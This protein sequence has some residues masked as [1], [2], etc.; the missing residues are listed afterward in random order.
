MTTIFGVPVDAAYHLVS[1]FTIVLTPV[2]GGLA[3]VAAIIAITVAVRLLLMPLSFRALRG[4][5]IAARLAPQLQVLRQRHAKQPERLQREMTALYKREGTS[6][7]ASITP[8]LLQWPLLSVMYL[9]FRSAQVGGKPNTLLTHDLFGVALGSHWLSGPG[10]ASVAGLVFLGVLALLAGLVWLSVRLSQLM[11][12]QATAVPAKAPAS[13]KAPVPARARAGGAQRAATKTAP[14]AAAQAPPVPGGALVK[15]LP[16]LTVVIAAFAPLAA[17]IYLIVSTGWSLV[18]RR[19][20][21]RSASA[22]VPP[23]QP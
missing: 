22:P 14:D 6:M 17:G 15:V 7:F 12:T 3:A 11:T 1:G 9:L 16:Y 10:P 8:F 4:Q 21:M 20:Y 18:E 19:L 5:A 23:P 2:L 13:A